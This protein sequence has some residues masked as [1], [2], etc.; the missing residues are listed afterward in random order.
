MRV[1]GLDVSG[2]PTSATLEPH[3]ANAGLGV[4]L[5]GS[6]LHLIHDLVTLNQLSSIALVA[7]AAP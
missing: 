3:Y 4:V 7:G 5:C 1:V 2:E 6:A